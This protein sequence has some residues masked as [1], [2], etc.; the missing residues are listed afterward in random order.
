M[1][2]TLLDHVSDKLIERKY[3]T[4]GMKRVDTGDCPTAREE[5]SLSI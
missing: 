4:Y 3:T 2:Y 1:C 5:L